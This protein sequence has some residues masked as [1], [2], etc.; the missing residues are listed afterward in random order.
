MAVSKNRAGPIVVG[1]LI[2]RALLLKGH[3]RAPDFEETC[4]QP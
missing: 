4:K 1:G 2:I 3:L